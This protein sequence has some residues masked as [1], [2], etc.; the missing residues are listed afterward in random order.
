MTPILAA[1]YLLCMLFL[2][3]F[4]G[5]VLLQNPYARTN[6]LFAW[7]SL[8]LFG[9]VATLFAFSL[10]VSSAPLLLVG[11]A[12]F[13]A[14]VFVVPLAFM[15]TRAVAGR[16]LRRSMSLI[17]WVIVWLMAALTALTPWIDRLEEVSVAGVHITSYGVL[18]PIYVLY[19]LGYFSAAVYTA[20]SR[21]VKLD[22]QRR[23][24]LTTLGVGILAT[25]LIS[26]VTNLLLP[27]FFG[28]FAFINI[29]TISTILFLAAAGYAVF[30]ERLF[31]P[32]LVIQATVIYGGL[33]ALALELYNVVLNFLAR[34][35]P[36]GNSS[37]RDFAATA[38][39]LVISAFTQQPISRW[40]ARLFKRRYSA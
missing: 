2:L 11:R 10:L 19:L 14:M 27:Y 36:L 35:L 7:L 40:L 20:F 24:Q 22:H 38:I 17:T 30:V 18:F 13:A 6:R 26:L 37:E 1:L 21:K 34:L 39:V 16:P 32:H 31:N 28:D 8:S 25:A 12:N 3:V 33:I 4:G 9:W 23:V 29:G 15:F 5:Y